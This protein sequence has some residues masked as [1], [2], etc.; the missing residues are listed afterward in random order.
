MVSRKLLCFV[1]VLIL[2]ITGS[3]AIAVPVEVGTGGNSADLY[4]E[5]SDGFAA[6]FIV[7]F[8]PPSISGLGL[9]DIIEA[10]TTLTT[11]RD[12]FGFG[13]FIDGITF[14]G[15]S[16][17]GYGGGEDWWHYWIKESDADW[18][19]PHYGVADRTITDGDS[20][21]W[22]YGSAGSPTPEPATIALL[23]FGGLLIR[24]KRT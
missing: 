4:I 1:Y 14:D 13:V 16:N 11:V 6:E 3:L 23:G 8:S 20:D 15:H 12:D 24:K 18:L 17:I 7:S 9:F 19:S 21:G 5:W 10:Q 2:V 22:I